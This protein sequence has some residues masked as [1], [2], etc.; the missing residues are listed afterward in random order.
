MFKLMFAFSKSNTLMLFEATF[1][2][3]QKM[4]EKFVRIIYISVQK[5][6]LHTLERIFFPAWSRT[7][8]NGENEN[9]LIYH[10]S[11]FL[12]FSMCY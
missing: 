9:I 8:L 12:Q 3:V 11:N 4:F 6:L 1:A 10:K 5:N 2:S 7:E